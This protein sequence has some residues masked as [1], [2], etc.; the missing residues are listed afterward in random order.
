M[1]KLVAA[2]EVNSECG[3][4]E[5]RPHGVLLE[6]PPRRDPDHHSAIKAAQERHPSS[7]PARD[8]PWLREVD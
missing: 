7:R 6:L 2:R 3:A 5:N 1:V 8:R 4:D